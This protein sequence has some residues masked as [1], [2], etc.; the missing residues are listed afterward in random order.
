[1]AASTASAVAKAA[2]IPAADFKKLSVA[3]AIDIKSLV[4]N[5]GLAYT[6][7]CAYY[8][9]TKPEEVPSSKSLIVEEVASG[10]MIVGDAVKTILGFD[11]GAKKK[12]DAKNHAGFNIYVRSDAASRRVDVGTHVV[13]LS[14]LPDDMMEVDAAAAPDAADAAGGVDRPPINPIEFMGPPAKHVQIAISFDTTGS[15]Y[16]YLDEVKRFAKITI[17]KLLNVGSEKVEICVIAHGDYCDETSYYLMK[18]SGFKTSSGELV[19]FVS[20][21]GRTGGGDAPEAYEYVLGKTLELPW[22]AAAQKS[23]IMLGD[24]LPH[25][26]HV[27]R[28]VWRDE[29]AKYAAQGIKIYAIQCGRNTRAKYFYETMANETDGIHLDLK[30]VGEITDFVLAIAY[31]EGNPRMIIAY[32]EELKK[33]G[34]GTLSDGLTKLFAKVTGKKGITLPSASS[35]KSGK[36]KSPTPDGEGESSA[37]EAAAKTTPPSKRT[38][39]STAAASSSSSTPATKKTPPTPAATAPATPVRVPR[40]LMRAASTL[41]S[42][43]LQNPQVLGGGLA[44]GPGHIGGAFLPYLPNQSQKQVALRDLRRRHVH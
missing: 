44:G 6:R 9:L 37:D 38:R 13:V 27:A 35:S 29:V 21:V 4:T 39:R 32:Q 20:E 42:E 11:K 22:D 3:T 19:S 18:S 34:G 24:D 36:R 14:K 31:A 10:R 26:D 25:E 43:L 15:M 5:N 40:P 7:G 12:V 1:M 33:R 28:Y 8:Q 17:D 30:D 41:E 2:E 16:S 23:L